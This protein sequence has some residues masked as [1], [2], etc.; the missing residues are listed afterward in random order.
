MASYSDEHYSD[1]WRPLARKVEARGV[2]GKPFCTMARLSE[3]ERIDLEIWGAPEGLVRKALG[4]LRSVHGL[5]TIP[6]P[7]V[8]YAKDWNDP[9][10]HCG[11][12]TWNPGARSHSILQSLRCPI[13]G[14]Y[15]CGEAYS[16]EQGWIEGALKSA[17]LVL[18]SMGLDPPRW[19]GE[20]TRQSLEAYCLA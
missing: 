20:H 15:I 8:A 13:R 16:T 7:L 17:E 3:L 12:H 2:P 6:E 19:L 11:W 18:M 4:Q 14:V 10:T 1:F 5:R 9:F